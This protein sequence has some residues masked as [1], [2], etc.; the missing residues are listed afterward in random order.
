MLVQR[1]WHVLHHLPRAKNMHTVLTC[2][3]ADL[4]GTPVMVLAPQVTFI[5]LS[6]SFLPLPKVLLMVGLQQN[7]LI[8]SQDVE[9]YSVALK[10]RFSDYDVFL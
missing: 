3:S 5:S 6:S 4:C 2:A 9:G 10:V 1:D 8:F 7:L